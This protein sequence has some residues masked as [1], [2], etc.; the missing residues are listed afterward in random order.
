VTSGSEDF[1]VSYIGL[2][3]S[4]K[5]KQVVDNTDVFFGIPLPA[6]LDSQGDVQTGPTNYTFVGEDFP[7]LLF[8]Y[9]GRFLWR[10]YT[11]PT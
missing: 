1:H 7:A 5:D 11:H 9:V 2:A 8:R 10:L 4:L 3:A 6:L